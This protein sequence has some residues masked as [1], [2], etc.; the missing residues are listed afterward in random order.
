MVLDD[1]VFG[2]VRPRSQRDQT[3]GGD[4]ALEVRRAVARAEESAQGGSRRVPTGDGDHRVRGD[5]AVTDG[6]VPAAKLRVR[7]FHH[8]RPDLIGIPVAAGDRG[9]AREAGVDRD[10]DR[11]ECRGLEPEPLRLLLVQSH[12]VRLDFPAGVLVLDDRIPDEG[13]ALVARGF[14]VQ[15][16]AGPGDERLQTVEGERA[17]GAASIGERRGR[18]RRR[19]R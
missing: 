9:V 2:V 12:G 15:R 18:R 10:G 11:G 1:P 6:V 8:E 17:A 7:L 3:A 19:G 4:V 13:T 14:A 16:S 5:P